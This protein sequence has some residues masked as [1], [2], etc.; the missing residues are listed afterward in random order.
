MTLR[1]FNFYSPSDD[2]G[3]M[4]VKASYSPVDSWSVSAGLNWFYGDQQDT[5]FAQFKDATNVYAS[6]RYFY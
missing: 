1:W 4:R 2:D 5:F 3:Y 6:Y